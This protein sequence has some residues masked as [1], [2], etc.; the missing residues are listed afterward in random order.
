MRGVNTVC[1]QRVISGNQSQESFTGR[2]HT[3]YNSD[4]IVATTSSVQSSFARPDGAQAA[5]SH[6][7]PDGQLITG[8]RR[9]IRTSPTG[10]SFTGPPA[11]AISHGPIGRSLRSR[12]RGVKLACMC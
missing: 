5:G 1:E 8:T 12:P 9:A 4:F 2:F 7:V 11:G 3:S 10:Y 6:H